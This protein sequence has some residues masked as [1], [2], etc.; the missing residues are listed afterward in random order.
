M[1][2]YTEINVAN[3]DKWPLPKDFTKSSPLMEKKLVQIFDTIKIEPYQLTNPVGI[4]KSIDEKNI[5]ILIPLLI[6]K[7]IMKNTVILY[8]IINNIKSICCANPEMLAKYNAEL[9]NNK[10]IK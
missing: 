2:G 1:G 10:N 8:N 3:E 4:I 9:I 6:N 5:H 7:R